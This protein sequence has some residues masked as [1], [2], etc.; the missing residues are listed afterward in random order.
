MESP[1]RHGALHDVNNKR[2]KSVILPKENRK[3]GIFYLFLEKNTHCRS[4]PTSRVLIYKK[5]CKESLLVKF[6]KKEFGN[7]LRE[8]RIVAHM[9]QDM[10]ADKVGVEKQHISRME[11]GLKSVSLNVLVE[12]SEE[13]NVSTDYLLRGSDNRNREMKEQIESIMNQLKEITKKL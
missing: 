10:L 11:R 12:L 13:L 6:N 8:R 1:K 9:T 7:R 4:P 2:W 3:C 5:Y